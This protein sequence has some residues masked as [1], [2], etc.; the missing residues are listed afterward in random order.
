MNCTGRCCS[1]I[2]ILSRERAVVR[3]GG[4]AVKEAATGAVRI[5]YERARRVMKYPR[6][7]GLLAEA[8][9]EWVERTTAR[10]N[11]RW[12]NL[13]GSLEVPAS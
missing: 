5:P 4:R 6:A 12:R 3:D 10:A 13:E 11:G 9:V 2:R 7:S 1:M 8:P